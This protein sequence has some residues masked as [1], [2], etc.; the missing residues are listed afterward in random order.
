MIP[1]TK[2]YLLSNKGNL[3]EGTEKNHEMPD[4]TWL[5]S[6]PRFESATLTPD[7]DTWKHAMEYFRQCNISGFDKH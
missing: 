7:T 4:S 3:P 2:A 5:L 1:E 6:Q